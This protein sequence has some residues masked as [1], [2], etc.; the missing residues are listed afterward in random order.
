MYSN[1]LKEPPRFGGRKIVGHDKEIFMFLWY[2]A[3]TLTFRQLGN[4]FDTANSTAWVLIDRV[5]SLL[6]S[7]GHFYI[8]WPTEAEIPSVADEFYKKKIIE[9]VIGAIDCTH[10]VINA[11]RIAAKADY[12]DRKK[13]TV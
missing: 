10:V 12:F 2:M 11:P 7:I 3:N 9:H 13:T 8:T 1:F 6:F 4:L 5:S